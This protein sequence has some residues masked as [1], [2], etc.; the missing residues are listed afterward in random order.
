MDLNILWFFLL[1][2]LLA[3]YAVL[4]GFDF[5][6]GI[7]MPLARSDREKRTIINA[8]GPLWDGN[9]VW[10]VTFGGAMFAAF[11][12]LYATVFSGFYNAFML[13][14]L[15]LILRAVSIEFRSKMESPRWRSFWDAGFFGSSL[16]AALLFGIATGAVMTG[17]PVDGRGIYT[18]GFFDIVFPP[19][20]PVFPLLV[21]LLSAALF[22]MHGAIYLFLK[23]EGELQQRVKQWMWHGF[24]IFL[25]LYLATTIMALTTVPHAADNFQIYPWTW[26]VVFVSILATAN[27]PRAVYLERPVEA[28]ISSSVLIVALVSLVGIA[29]YPNVLV[30]STS[31]AFN[32]T[33]YS[34]A[35]SEKT[36][37][38][39]AIIAGL[40]MPFVLAY[41]A[42]IY[43][44]Y[45]GKVRLEEH[46]Y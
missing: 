26:L 16:L 40:G 13:V 30:S 45:R 21:G 44:T 43:W 29:L 12:E 39:M 8:I 42:I 11:P 35:S 4:D 24:G 25:V 20:Q 36:L 28:F 9:E 18:G 32:L 17:V 33:I 14:L 34:A 19:H 5:G 37:G 31:T 7:L 27:I 41:T 15:A 6:C 22:T 46:S 10:L 23:T 1:G 38:I 2:V 3:G